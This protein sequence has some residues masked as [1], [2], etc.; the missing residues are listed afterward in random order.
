MVFVVSVVIPCR[1]SI[2]LLAEQLAALSRQVCTEEWEVVIADNTTNRTDR[3]A[4]DALSD[5]YADSLP[6]LRVIRAVTNAGAGYA[7][8]VGVK[9]AR[10]DKL[11][12]LDADDVA[13]DGWLQA[14]ADA[15]EEHD[16]VTSRWD[17]ERLNPPDVRAGRK[18]AQVTGPSSYRKPAFLNHSGGCGMGV[19]RAAFEAV[20]GFDERF[21]LLE[22]TDIS[23]RLQLAGYPLVFVPDALVHI[24]FRPTASAS[25]RQ[26]FGYGKYNVL[27]YK[28]FRDKG[29]PAL[30]R[31]SIFSAGYRIVK[32]LFG[33]RDRGRRPRVIW[34]LGY[35]LGR[36]AGS[37]AFVVW[38]F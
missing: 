17:I 31:T 35:L 22:D 37:V 18:N 23:W 4:L 24:R 5:R 3:R 15:L 28:R 2:E 36:I 25:F 9:S 29:M 7:R 10:G 12:F 38:G 19:T 20:G 8:N 30:E 11:A 21:R 27:L 26:S 6:G 34:S 1:F 32:Y 13:A 16:F 14:M 33:L